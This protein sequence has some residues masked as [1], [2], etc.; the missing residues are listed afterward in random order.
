MNLPSP[1][2]SGYSITQYEEEPRYWVNE[3]KGAENMVRRLLETDWV[4]FRCKQANPGEAGKCDGCDRAK[5]DGHGIWAYMCKVCRKVCERDRCAC[6]ITNPYMVKGCSIRCRNAYCT[7]IHYKDADKARARKENSVFRSPS[8]R[9]GCLAFALGVSCWHEKC[10]FSHE[11]NDVPNFPWLKAR[12]NTWAIGFV[13]K[14]DWQARKAIAMAEAAEE[15]ARRMERRNRENGDE[16]ASD[17][18]CIDDPS[19]EWVYFM[20]SD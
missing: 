10:K 20:Y 2:T 16:S 1:S 19:D 9:R 11:P 4:C 3:N 7:K 12:K 18:H 14:K 8:G 13:G 17:D 15:E 5:H 6:Q